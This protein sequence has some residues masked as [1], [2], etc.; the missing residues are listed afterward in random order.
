MSNEGDAT[1]G[2]TSLA[3]PATMAGVDEVESYA[4]AFCQ[5]H[6]I[7]SRLGRVLL[8][9]LEE[10][11]TNTVTHGQAPEESTIDVGLRRDRSHISLSYRDRGIPF[12]PVKDRKPQD[13][14]QTMRSRP[15]GGVGWPLIFH[16][17]ADVTYRRIDD[18][19]VMEMV[20]PLFEDSLS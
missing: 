2:T 1:A 13:M 20:I 10:L 18:A 4:N 16:Y 3:I 8:L 9:I 12:D 7:G 5:E 14:S 17:C 11:V 6:Q 19:N 15:P